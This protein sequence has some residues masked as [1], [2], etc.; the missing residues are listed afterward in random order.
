M[1]GNH[2]NI[3]SLEKI[4][5]MLSSFECTN[6]SFTLKFEDQRLYERGYS[7]WNW[8]NQDSNRTFLLVAGQGHCGSNTD[9]LPFVVNKVLFNNATKSMKALGH[10]STWE[11]T[12]HSFELSAGS[13]QH[14]ALSRGNLSKR[15]IKKGFGLS[16]EGDIPVS[17]IYLG[18]GPLHF[19]YDC[20]GCKMTGELEFQ[21][22][23]H[24]F[25]HIPY[26]FSMS[27][28]PRGIGTYWY[29]HVYFE[30][31]FPHT[32]KTVDLTPKIPFY[33]DPLHIDGLVN[34][35]PSVVGAL[36]AIFGP[37]YANVG[38][39][40]GGPMSISNSAEFVIDFL[41]AKVSV[42]GWIPHLSWDKTIFDGGINGL[43]QIRY[44]LLAQVGISLF[45]EWAPIPLYTVV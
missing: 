33:D 15:D 29:P 17:H 40:L 43:F 3:I 38:V 23:V 13:Y 42:H 37:I 39:S 19:D 25:W 18:E 14:P 22:R 31:D 5:R 36:Q 35:G 41:K 27:I 28:K 16:I 12:I 26:D 45:S 6:N 32:S 20:F 44:Q 11:L 21:F 30:L 7:S 2:E 24:T 1:P 34:I 4:Y 9:R 10:K 8:V